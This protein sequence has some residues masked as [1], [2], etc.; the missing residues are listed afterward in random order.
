S[1]QNSVFASRTATSSDSSILSAATSSSAVSGVYN[2]RINTI[3]TA[4]EI[5]SQGFDSLSSI[6]SQGSLQLKIGNASTTITVDGTN[7]TLQGL[8]NAIN[9][10]GAAVT[11]N[12]VNDGSG[13]GQQG[14]RL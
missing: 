6:I 7:N 4:N 9:T 2:L 13:D 11:A 8:A 12:V 14:Y 10:S 3:A 5:A 1:S